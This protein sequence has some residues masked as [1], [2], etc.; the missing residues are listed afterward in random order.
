MSLNEGGDHRMDNN[1]KRTRTFAGIAVVA[2]SLVLAVAL[3]GMGFAASGGTK[4][5]NGP[6][7]SQYGGKIT[8]CHHTKSLKN[9]VVTIRISQSAWPAHKA[10]GDTLGPCTALQIKHA[11][12]VA[13]AKLAKLKAKAKAK[14]K[15]KGHTKVAVNTTV[16]VHTNN[17]N[18]NGNNGNN[19]NN[20]KGH[21]K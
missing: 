13:H 7:A 10:H 15:A 14:A 2:V 21:G 9:P 5:A 12:A 1:R 16:V 3:A 8:I 18:G 4:A 11:K 6:A 20:G 17:G 19:G